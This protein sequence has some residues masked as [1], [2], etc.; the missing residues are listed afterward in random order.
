MPSFQMSNQLTNSRTVR[1]VIYA[2]QQENLAT[3]A[4][5][6]EIL[7]Y[8]NGAPI[9]SPQ[10][11]FDGDVL[12]TPGQV[13][14]SLLRAQAP[15]GATGSYVDISSQSNASFID[16]G[17]SDNSTSDYNSRILSFLPNPAFP[18]QSNLAIQTGGNVQVM[19][20][21]QLG[22][23][24]APAFKC[25]YGNTGLSPG[26]NIVGKIPFTPGLFTTVP[27]VVVTANTPTGSSGDQF[28]HV[29]EV[30]TATF[31]IEYLGAV[32]PGTS[33][34]WIALGV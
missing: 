19:G 7:Y 25:D 10:L 15:G 5:D 34:N 8:S 9:S 29:E 33:V 23:P 30:G 3:D 27:V 18:E 28:V 13:I 1:E 22:S 16:F 26:T 31:Q 11:T 21:I 32:A 6:T 12:R 20:P 17:S 24:I 4:N 2:N 14:G